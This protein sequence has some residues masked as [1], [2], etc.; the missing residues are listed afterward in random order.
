ME[1]GIKKG[2]ILFF[3][4]NNTTHGIGN[5]NILASIFGGNELMKD[6]EDLSVSVDL[7]VI[8]KS[9][10]YIIDGGNNATIS[11]VASGK[12]SNFLGGMK[13]GNTNVL[14]TYFT[15]IKY[16]E[17]DNETLSEALSIKSIDIEFNSWYV[18]TVTI[19]FVDV[20]GAA[21]FSP[22]EH[23]QMNPDDY[24]KDSPYSA[25]FTMPYPQFNL[26][27]K[28][29]YGDAVSY[30]LHLLDF[31]STFSSSTGNFE[32]NTTFIGYTYA[33]LNDIQM[34]YLIV[35]PYLD[36]YGAEYWKSQEIGRAS[37]RE[38]V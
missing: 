15:D 37:C 19:N 30:P 29:V 6:P 36:L 22:S 7:E 2:K 31:K 12:K 10:R 18:A 20:R 13:L 5:N 17:T 11:S 14:S 28:G 8:N 33:I 24:L 21:L 26:K 1:D 9:R 38:R 4:P 23:N 25:F 34:T 32:I 35:S 3:D 16:D 27:V